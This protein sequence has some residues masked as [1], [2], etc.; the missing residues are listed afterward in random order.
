MTKEPAALP[1]V[2]KGNDAVICRKRPLWAELIFALDRWLQRRQGVFEYTDKPDCIF[3][4]Q[5]GRLHS[6]VMLSDG[7]AGHPG[8]RVIDLHFW[9]EHIPAT[10]LAKHS[11]AWARHFGRNFAESIDELA[12]FLSSEPGLLDINIV[13]ANMNLDSLSRIAARY[14]FEITRE[15]V[16]IWPS[17]YVHR[18]GENILYW[19]LT[20]ACSSGRPRPKKFWRSRQPIYLSRKVLTTARASNKETKSGSDRLQA[21]RVFDQN[22]WAAVQKASA[23]SPLTLQDSP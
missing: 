14:G 5:L 7:T 2:R 23:D 11:F 20:L 10:P 22:P 12:R 1:F 8:D 9:N 15:P 21:R 17:Q 13:R 18:F 19:L 4:V 16:K 3:R 6:Q